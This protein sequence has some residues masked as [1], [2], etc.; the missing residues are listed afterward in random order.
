MRH[1]PATP[2]IHDLARSRQYARAM[3]TIGKYELRPEHWEALNA[4]ADQ[5]AERWLRL[6]GAVE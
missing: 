3:D 1:Q 4:Y 6:H 5:I 2:T